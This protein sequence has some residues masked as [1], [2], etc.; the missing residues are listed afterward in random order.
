MAGDKTAQM[1]AM[2]EDLIKS[3][4]M[5]AEMKA[6]VRKFSLD[7]DRMTDEEDD[8]NNPNKRHNNG[9]VASTDLN[10]GWKN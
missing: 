6:A 1:A 9:S 2:L 8:E 4:T 5:T 7:P 10:L 3:G